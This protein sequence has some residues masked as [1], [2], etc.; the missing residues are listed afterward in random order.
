MWLLCKCLLPLVQPFTLVQLLCKRCKWHSFASFISMVQGMGFIDRAANVR[1][2][3]TTGG[4]V[5]MAVERLL[6]GA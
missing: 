4:D 3:Q 6:S 5:N 1:A 2:L